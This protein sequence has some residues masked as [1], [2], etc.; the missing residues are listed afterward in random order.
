MIKVT[1]AVCERVPLVPV[2]VSGKVPVAALTVVVIVRVVEP[3]VV[4]L[5]GAKVPVAPLPRPLTLNV[6]VL[7]NPPLGVI[8]TV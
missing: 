8:V 3:E 6:T 2:M 7:L 4:T 5:T 1:E